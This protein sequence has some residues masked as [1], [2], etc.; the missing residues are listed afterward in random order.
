MAAGIAITVRAS[1][2]DD[3]TTTGSEADIGELIQKVA[4]NIYRDTQP[5]R[6]AVYLRNHGQVDDSIAILRTLVTPNMPALDRAFAYNAWG[7]TI[8][9]REG[10]S[11]S[12]VLM[13]RS[14]ESYPAD[15]ISYYTIA[16]VELSK[17][18]S[19][20]AL[21]D[22]KTAL[23]LSTR[24]SSEIATRDATKL[25]ETLYKGTVDAWLGDYHDLLL[26]LRKTTFVAQN[27]FGPTTD[28]A[29]AE[30][31]EHDLTAARDSLANPLPS[32][33]P[34]KGASIMMTIST[35]MK[36]DS[37]AQ[38]WGAVIGEGGQAAALAQKYPGLR[39]L[40]PTMSDPLLAYVEARQGNFAAAEARINATPAD[41]YICLRM[42]ARIAE[43][44]E[45][46]TRSDWWFARAVEIG[47]SLPFAETEWGQVLLERGQPDA[48]IAEFKLANKKGVHF[49]DPLEGWGEALMAKNQSYRALA[50]FEEANKYAR[51]WGR[52][53]LKWGE[54]LGFVERKDEASLQYR[55]AS[56]LDL[57]A[58]DRAEL[59]K[60]SA[61]G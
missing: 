47:P 2:V 27:P 38:D 61:H 28:I 21:R 16:F 46:H 26:Q 17:G 56:T 7:Q 1:N 48:A 57:T 29:I 51:N 24:N 34:L 5:Y 4:E 54:A 30:I 59:A 52:L 32:A 23:S 22:I 39:T 60:V 50:K 15:F 45:Q 36:L 8:L 41:C 20:V 11:Q 19:E 18:Q 55:R 3:Y 10:P 33:S 43:I 49:A 40:L 6:Y 35:V 25:R 9:D 42:R 53:H 14:V 44:K 37:E 13:K 31:G 12:L 58:A